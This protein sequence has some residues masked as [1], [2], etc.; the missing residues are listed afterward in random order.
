MSFQLPIDKAGNVIKKNIL[1]KLN[2]VHFM[3]KYDSIIKGCLYP[4]YIISEIESLRIRRTE[5]EGQLKQLAKDIEDKERLKAE[6][7]MKLDSESESDAQN[8]RKRK[9]V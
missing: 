9:K 8:S 4:K 3:L 6:L 2:S 7:F 5:L 1:N